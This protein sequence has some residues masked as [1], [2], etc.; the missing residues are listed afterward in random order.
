MS[1]TITIPTNCNPYIVV[2]NNHVYAYRAG[3][4]IEVP[5]EVAEA[6]ALHEKVR[7]EQSKAFHKSTA[8]RNVFVL[9]FSGIGKSNLVA[10]EGV[11]LPFDAKFDYQTILEAAKKGTL[12]FVFAS[13]G[14][15]IAVNPQI[16]TWANGLIEAHFMLQWD[17]TNVY[18][19]AFNCSKDAGYFYRSNMYSFAVT[20]ANP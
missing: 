20:N 6:I 19:F 4:T 12:S 10:K 15:T 16:R 5:D 7:Q 1:K 3:D 18:W 11:N 13:D 17:N 14:G 9:E 8:E 2:I